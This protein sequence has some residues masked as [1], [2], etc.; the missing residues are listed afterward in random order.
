MIPINSETR[1]QRELF[2]HLILSHFDWLV[3]NIFRYAAITKVVSLLNSFNGDEIV[4]LVINCVR[5]RKAI[6]VFLPRVLRY[7]A[8]IDH[9][10]IRFQD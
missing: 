9:L 3:L 8:G 2:A 1:I 5:K 7:P 4:S 6:E 10:A